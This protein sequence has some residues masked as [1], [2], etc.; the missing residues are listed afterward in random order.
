MSHSGNAIKSKT[1]ASSQLSCRLRSQSESSSSRCSLKRIV[2]PN[3]NGS[4][5]STSTIS[6]PSTNLC[7][8]CRGADLRDM[9][10]NEAIMKFSEKI[11]AYRDLI[12]SLND[13]NSTLNHTL[14]TIQYPAF[15]YTY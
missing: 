13:N 7:K 15:Y 12:K 3:K 9:N 1:L 2:T 5:S 4:P 8:A 14:D 10:L 11:D 6:I